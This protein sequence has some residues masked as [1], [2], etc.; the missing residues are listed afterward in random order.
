M[1]FMVRST[2][3]VNAVREDLAKIPAFLRRDLLILWS[4]RTAFF[5]DWVN[6][7]VQVM[8]FYFL[9]RIIPSDRLPE[10]GGRPTTYIQ[11]V[12]VAIALT[13]FLSISLGRV[14][15]AV[16]TEQNQG[17]LEALL[18]T[19]TASSTLQLGWVMY[20]LLYFPLRT[21]V[22]L[23]LMSVLLG[24]TLS[25]AG[26]LPT[27]VMFI[28]FIP[29]VWGIGVISGAVILTVR[30]GRGLVGL[31]AVFLTLTSGAYFPIQNFPGWLQQI[32]EFNPMT[33]VLNGAREALL[34][35]P[36]W[37]VVW[38]VIP[39]LIPLAVVTI[40]IG[41]LAFRLALRRERRRGT[42]GLY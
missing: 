12:T 4:Y 39:T 7:L 36:D 25:P 17:T 20:D 31:V 23:I 1:S 2:G 32:A 27:V 34:G 11:Y 16:S 29:F 19:P 28:P 42:L 24:V 41:A 8:V 21:A 22:F 38:S 13:A 9:S 26:I 3:M 5:S 33:R 10:Y 6:I 40:T 37:S 35:S 14:T 18:M 15:T 30:R